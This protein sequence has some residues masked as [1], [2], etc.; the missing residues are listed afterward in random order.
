MFGAIKPYEVLTYFFC[1]ADI[2]D[3]LNG[4]RLSFRSEC[5]IPID[6][7]GIEHLKWD[8][9]D[10]ELLAEEWTNNLRN[11]YRLQDYAANGSLDT[12][13]VEFPIG[14]RAAHIADLAG[15]EF[16]N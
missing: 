16:R 15:A 1:G 6:E 10:S 4:L 7:S 11:M 9:P 8:L 12:L 5:S 13:K 14:R 2:F 3:G